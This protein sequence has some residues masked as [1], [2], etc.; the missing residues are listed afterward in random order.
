MCPDCSLIEIATKSP[1]FPAPFVIYKPLKIKCMSDVNR[2]DFLK[3][4]ILITAGATLFTK[5]GK[6]GFIRSVS[7]DIATV[8]GIDYFA[9]T[10]R[11]IENLGGISK[12]VPSG[13]K[14]GII[15]NAPNWWAKPG[16]HTNTDVV[17][18]TL[19]M[20]NDAG[21]KEITYLSR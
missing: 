20:L 8:A 2:R 9:N 3:K 11:A 1:I 5:I 7:N 19:K 15:V 12:F 6:A 13:S 16:S 14:I 10:I 17:L 21:A 4:S 18:A